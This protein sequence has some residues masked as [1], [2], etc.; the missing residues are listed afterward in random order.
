MGFDILAINPVTTS[1]VYAAAVDCSEGDRIGTLYRTADSGQNWTVVLTSTLAIH[2]LAIDH[3]R[4][5]TVYAADKEYTVYKSTDG[6]DSWAIIRHPP[7]QPSDPPSGELLAMDPLVPTYLYLAG[8]DW[9]GR[10][11]DGGSTWEDLYSGLPESMYPTALTVDSSIPTQTLY[12]GT[13]G[14]WTYSHKWPGS[15]IRLPL[16]SKNY[17]PS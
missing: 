15:L 8:M 6:G 13:F 2:S 4:P 10:S 5:N 1:I 17:Q 16:L 12:L 9:V 11:S 7:Q 3:W 14:V